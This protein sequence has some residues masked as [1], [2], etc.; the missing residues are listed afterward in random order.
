M[1]VIGTN[2]EYVAC[3]VREQFSKPRIIERGAA[4]V[5]V[6]CVIERVRLRTFVC[7]AHA[8]PIYMLNAVQL[9]DISCS[10]AVWSC[11]L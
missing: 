9:R 5:Y 3:A 11:T 10:L 4:Y 1:I 8:T 2:N 7:S 6:V